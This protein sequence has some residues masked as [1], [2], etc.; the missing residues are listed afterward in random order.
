HGRAVP[1]PIE[2]KGSPFRGLAAFG[3]KH[4]PVFFGRS[5]D[6][7]RAVDQWKQA[8]ALGTPFLLLI[9]A[10]GAGKSSLARAGLVPRLTAPGVV[11]TVDF[12]R[13]AVMRPSEAPDG[14]IMSL[15]MRLFDAT[16]DITDEERGRA[17]ALPEIRESDFRTPAELARLFAE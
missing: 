11:P 12:W 8:A 13:V 10:S 7:T 15:A 4:A 16:D 9:G 17:P 6:V 5:R 3:V 2:F 14:P 1:W